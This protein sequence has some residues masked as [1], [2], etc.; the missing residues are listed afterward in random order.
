MGRSVW[1]SALKNL[2][3]TLKRGKHTEVDPE[4]QRVAGVLGRDSAWTPAIT[5]KV[6]G[7]ASVIVLW[8]YLGRKSKGSAC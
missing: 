7:T 2:P 6:L 8:F 4:S 3:R 5:D 1:T